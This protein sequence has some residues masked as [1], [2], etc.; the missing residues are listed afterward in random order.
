MQ[1]KF[2]EVRDNATCMPVLAIKMEAHDEVSKR[3]LLRGVYPEDGS[4]IIL[5][6][7]SDQSASVD[8][9]SWGGRTRP[10]A[11]QHI[12]TNFDKLK[13]GSVVDVRAILGETPIVAAPEVMS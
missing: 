9:H 1:L 8:P 11:H 2:F 7:L 13:D 6:F 5:M 4:A 10:V 12:Y 3:F